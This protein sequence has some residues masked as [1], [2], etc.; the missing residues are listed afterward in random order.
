MSLLRRT[1][2]RFEA[3]KKSERG[4]E[5]VLC[6]GVSGGVLAWHKGSSYVGWARDLT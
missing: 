6:V 3:T 2:F 4:G 1:V 5:E